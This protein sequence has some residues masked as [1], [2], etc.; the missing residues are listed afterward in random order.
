[1][2]RRVLKEEGEKTKEAPITRWPAVVDT[3]SLFQ[4]IP[5]S[6]LWVPA[7]N[8]PP[9]LGPCS[10]GAQV[11]RLSTVNCTEARLWSPAGL[12]LMELRM[13]EPRRP[14]CFSFSMHLC[15]CVCERVRACALY[16]GLFLFC[17]YIFFFWKN[18]NHLNSFLRG[19]STHEFIQN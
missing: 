9:G 12:V 17:R 3:G 15:V 16:S 4:A 10:A 7:V 11:L 8:L 2:W 13:A 5:R 14:A 19:P 18:S 6:I 1:M